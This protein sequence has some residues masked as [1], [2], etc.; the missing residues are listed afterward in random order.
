MQV[1]SES[2]VRRASERRP[3]YAHEGRKPIHA[4]SFVSCSYLH[5]LIKVTELEEYVVNEGVARARALQA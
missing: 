1:G 4:A 3:H 2:V 5:T